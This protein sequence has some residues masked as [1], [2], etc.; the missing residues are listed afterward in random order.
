MTPSEHIYRA[1]LAAYPRDYRAARGDEV[2]GTMLDATEGRRL[3][4]VRE[5]GSV[6]ADGYRRRVLASITPPH[7]A[8]RA[9][10]AWAAFALAVLT[11]AVAVVGMMR[12]D[13]LANS[14]PPALAP[15]QHLL[16]LAVTPWFAAFA[17]A[18]VGT[19]IA[20]AVSARR[21]ALACSLA[22]ALV[23]AWE[24]AFGPAA[25]FP[26]TH[27][28]F[29]V[30]AWTN[31]STLPREPWH[32]LVPGLL[33]PACVLLAGRRPA[34]GARVRAVRAVSALALAAGLAVATDHL[35]GGVA[36]LGILLIP[37]LAT[38][39]ALSPIDP[40][41]ALACVPLLA[42]AL[43]L[44]WTYTHADPTTP[45]AGDLT[46]LAGIVLGIAAFAAAGAASARGLRGGT[47]P[48]S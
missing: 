48:Q 6:I 23:Q 43:P 37:L 21:A 39:V 29:A 44:A 35:Y 13:H 4:D 16:G 5:V 30:Y 18:A 19:L 7:G 40:R 41:P 38:A 10:A 1:A 12:E 32:W 28:H 17:A 31:V 46:V 26:G 24:A 33:L 47:P 2:L 42:T 15:H 45:A 25:G 34:P 20:L 14:L 9:A 11:A 36:G 8:L 27:G 3:P 22:G